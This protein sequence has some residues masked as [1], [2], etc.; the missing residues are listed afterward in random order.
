MRRIS[1]GELKA[2]CFP[3][4]EEVERSRVPVLITRNGRPVATLVP[5]E[6]VAS[7]VF[8]AYA[9]VREYRRRCRAAGRFSADVEDCAVIPLDIP[10][11]SASAPFVHAL[12]WR[13]LR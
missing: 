6:E 13:P 3:I 2:R 4:M 9:R 5:A 12:D 11:R 7:D 8:G 10:R 1:A